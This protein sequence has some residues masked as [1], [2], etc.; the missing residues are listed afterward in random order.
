MSSYKLYYFNGRGRAEIA[1]LI[2]AAAGRAFEDI[3]YDHNEWKS[4]KPQMLLGQIPIL[5]F[6]GIKL[7]QSLSIARFLAKQFQLAGRDNFRTS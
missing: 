6:N 4:H 1:R 7:P 2:F 3:R 5:E